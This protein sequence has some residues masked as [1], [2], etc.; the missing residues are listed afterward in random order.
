MLTREE[1]SCDEGN[2]RME[3]DW[4]KSAKNIWS[5]PEEEMTECKDRRKDAPY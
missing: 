2:G 1:G 3:V 5:L 4:R